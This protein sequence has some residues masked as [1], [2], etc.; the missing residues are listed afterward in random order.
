MSGNSARTPII[1]RILD[2]QCPTRVYY[3]GNCLQC[4]L[5]LVEPAQEC[6]LHLFTRPAMDVLEILQ[7]D[8]GKATP[9][10]SLQVA[11]N[12]SYMI[13]RSGLEVCLASQVAITKTARQGAVNTGQRHRRQVLGH[14]W[15][16]PGES[17]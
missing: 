7:C 15:L 2:L 5:L 13:E 4:E 3:T 11:G 1:R 12:G 17:Q 16:L 9:R 6:F 14:V 10:P 8:N